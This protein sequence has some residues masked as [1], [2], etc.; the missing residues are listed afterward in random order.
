MEKAKTPTERLREAL[1]G[2]RAAYGVTADSWFFSEA[3]DALAELTA[4]TPDQRA[5]RLL[6]KWLVGAHSYFVHPC[7]PD[8]SWRF[9]C[10]GLVGEGSTKAE[11]ILDA[12]RKAGCKDV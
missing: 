9:T 11:A 5:E 1:E 10:T 6:G 7:R 4:E 12:L 3:R 2:L 8:P